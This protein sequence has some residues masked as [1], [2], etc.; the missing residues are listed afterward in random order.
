MSGASPISEDEQRRIDAFLRLT[1]LER[2]L[3]IFIESELSRADGQGWEKGLPAD[4]RKKVDLAGLEF[5]DFPDLKKIIGSSWKKFDLQQKQA[6]KQRILIHLEGLEPVRNDIAH[7][8]EISED[9]LALIQA[10]YHTCRALLATTNAESLPPTNYPL[11]AL[12]RIEAA[13]EYCAAVDEADLKTL[14]NDQLCRSAH[15]SVCAYVRVRERPG[16]SPDLMKRVQRDAI[17][18]I[19]E[20]RGSIEGN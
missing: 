18:S 20:T 5:T 19:A 8:R 9:G 16:R 13:V 1:R 6:N 7:S 2:G 11:V 3:R 14:K 4:V 12:E 10:A 15:D 17:S